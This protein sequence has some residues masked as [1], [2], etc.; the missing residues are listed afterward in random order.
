MFCQVGG[1][2][3]G[4]D[5]QDIIPSSTPTPVIKGLS[6]TPSSFSSSSKSTL[7]LQR[8]ETDENELAE[9]ASTSSTVSPYPPTS[10]ST[11]TSSPTTPSTSIAST[12]EK[13]KY[14]IPHI[15]YLSPSS[16]SS[17]ARSNSE[18]KSQ[19]EKDGGILID[20]ERE[21]MLKFLVGETG[22]KHG[23]LPTMVRFDD[24]SPSLAYWKV[25][26]ANGNM[27]LMS[28]LHS[29][30]LGSSLCSKNL[31]RKEIGSR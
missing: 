18:A 9:Y 3:E 2:V 8:S 23:K 15:S 24:F 27:F 31:E 12:K 11:S 6:T 22:K 10:T 17:P 14:L 16:S 28:R 21:L 29:Q 7:E 26:S 19:I 30:S 1:F 5:Q 4:P 13:S 20:G 25:I